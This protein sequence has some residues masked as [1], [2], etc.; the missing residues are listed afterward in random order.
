MNICIHNHGIRWVQYFEGIWE[1][2]DADMPYGT[3]A[4]VLYKGPGIGYVL[5]YR[6]I[7]NYAMR[8]PE[9]T[10]P[11]LDAAIGHFAGLLA[12]RKLKE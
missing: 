4:R 9:E 3:V 8:K 2:S 7:E 5:C 10:F 11:T 12:I 1:L 6:F